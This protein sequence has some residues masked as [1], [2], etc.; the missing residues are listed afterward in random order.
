MYRMTVYNK[1]LRFAGRIENWNLGWLLDMG[2]KLQK[3]YGAFYRLEFD[4]KKEGETNDC[5]RERNV[6]QGAV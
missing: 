4:V 1:D 2:K 5:G 3:D 6:H